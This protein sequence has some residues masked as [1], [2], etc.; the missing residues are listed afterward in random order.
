MLLSRWTR[1]AP[2]EAARSSAPGPKALRRGLP[3][4]SHLMSQEPSEWKAETC[5]AGAAWLVTQQ[6]RQHCRRRCSGCSNTSTSS[7]DRFDKVSSHCTGGGIS[8]DV[9]LEKSGREKP[10]WSLEEKKSG[11]D[12]ENSTGSRVSR[13]TINGHDL[14]RSRE[15]L[16]M[17]SGNPSPVRPH[18]L[19]TCPQDERRRRACT[20]LCHLIGIPILPAALCLVTAGR[21]RRQP[22][23]ASCSVEAGITLEQ[24]GST[25]GCLPTRDIDVEK[26]EHGLGRDGTETS[27]RTGVQL[28]TG[29]EP[30]TQ[31]PQVTKV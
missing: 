9:S 18:H 27:C 23:R 11:V 29:R 13:V 22:G 5:P 20:H 1:T 17:L 28:S 24:R 21:A 14:C 26:R 12:K 4:A 8:G 6:S 3:V 19:A 10:Q 30:T 25:P 15:R 31:P 7:S 16:V 2:P